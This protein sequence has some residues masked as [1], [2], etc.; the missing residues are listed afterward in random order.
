MDAG[1]DS[2]HV[3]AG[4]AARRLYRLAFCSPA[5][6]AYASCNQYN[7]RTAVYAPLVSMTKTR[8]QSTVSAWAH[9]AW[10][11]CVREQTRRSVL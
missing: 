1:K 9:F 2:L 3:E 11:A 8:G 4:G 5:T 10:L 7:V 6:A